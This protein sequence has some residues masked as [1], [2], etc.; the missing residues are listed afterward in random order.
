MK[1]PPK[2]GAAQ[3]GTDAAALLYRRAASIRAVVEG[4]ANP[5]SE[6]LQ[7][8]G[9]L[10]AGLDAPIAI[11]GGLAAIHHGAEVTTL[12]IDV[13]LSKDQLDAILIEGPRLGLSLKRKSPAGWHRFLFEGPSGKV[14]VHIVPEGAKSPRDPAHAPANPGPPELGVSRGLGYASFGPWAAMKLVAN[15]DKDRYHIVEALKR[16]SQTQ[17]SEVIQKLRGLHPSYLAELERLLR[18]A[19]EEKAQGE[20]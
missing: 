3:A 19:E 11:V 12:D 1:T 14:E 8:L 4:E 15:R 20:W 17:I 18:S 16:A 10:A 9:K 5:F 6:C 7:A 2:P 13:T